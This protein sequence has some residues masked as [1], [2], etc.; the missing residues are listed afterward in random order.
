MACSCV[1]SYKQKLMRAIYYE[2]DDPGYT[3]Y[4]KAE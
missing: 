2:Q 3:G 1:Y 4:V